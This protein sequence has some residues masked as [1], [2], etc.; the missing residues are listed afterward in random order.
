[1]QSNED[2]GKGT[3]EVIKMQVRVTWVVE[4]PWLVGW[5]VT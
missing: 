2:E 5:L 3:A 4:T 1:M